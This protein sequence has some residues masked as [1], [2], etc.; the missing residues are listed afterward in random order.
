MAII[1]TKYGDTDE[2]DL[3]KLEGEDET[4]HAV[5]RWVEY[6]FPGSDEIVH[7]SIHGMFKQ[8][9]VAQALGEF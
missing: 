3:E 9:I 1:P 6:R 5:V 4:E 8:G 2:A 7:R